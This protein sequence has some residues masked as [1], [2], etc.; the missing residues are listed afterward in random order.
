L[1][2]ARGR[3]GCRM[4]LRSSTTVA[5]RPKPACPPAEITQRRDGSDAPVQAGHQVGS[6]SAHSR[7]PGI[8]ASEGVLLRP[9]TPKRMGRLRPST[10]ARVAQ[11]PGTPEPPGT[12]PQPPPDPTAAPPYEEP[13]RPIPIPRPE[14]PPVIDDPPPSRNR[15]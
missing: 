14:V 11:Q 10:S 4:R 15:L 9:R 3:A 1:R 13:P 2:R 5:P 6:G 7:P 12:P 8:E